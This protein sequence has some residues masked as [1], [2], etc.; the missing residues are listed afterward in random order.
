MVKRFEEEPDQIEL[1][2]KIVT[3]VS[4]QARI[5][6]SESCLILFLK[7]DYFGFSYNSEMRARNLKAL[8][9][10]QERMYGIHQ[11]FEAVMRRRQGGK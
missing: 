5:A 6:D 3:R 4:R 9:R 2:N 8:D 11:R 10:F 7:E 1:A